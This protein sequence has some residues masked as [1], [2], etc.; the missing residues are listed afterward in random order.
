MLIQLHV[1]FDLRSHNI[2]HAEKCSIPGKFKRNIYISLLV[3][4]YSK[5]S[6]FSN[7]NILSELIF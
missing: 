6:Y 3:F 7:P 1:L 5:T 4:K 2:E